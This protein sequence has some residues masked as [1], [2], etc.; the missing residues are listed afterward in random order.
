MEVLIIMLP[1][2]YVVVGACVVYATVR[3]AIVH[4]LRQARGEE[5]IERRLPNAATWLDEDERRLLDVSNA[6]QDGTSAGH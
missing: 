1:I 5:R 3:F 2:L 4:A 6:S